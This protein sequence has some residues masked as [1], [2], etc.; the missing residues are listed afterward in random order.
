MVMELKLHAIELIFISQLWLTKLSFLVHNTTCNAPYI[1]L[2]HDSIVELLQT[3]PNGFSF[4]RLVRASI[5][6][7]SIEVRTLFYC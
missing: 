6:V 4:C 2:S 1:H 5:G 7:N 3:F